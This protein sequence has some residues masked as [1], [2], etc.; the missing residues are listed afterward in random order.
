MNTWPENLLEFMN[1]NTK[2]ELKDRLHG[3]VCATVGMP[4]Q[5][6][7]ALMMRFTCGYDDVVIAARL[8]ISVKTVKASLQRAKDYLNQSTVRPLIE[9]GYLNG[10]N[11][12]HSIFSVWEKEYGV[13]PVDVAF[14]E[15]QIRSALLKSGITTVEELPADTISIRGIGSSYAE[16]IKQRIKDLNGISCFNIKARAEQTNEKISEVESEVINCEKQI[17]YTK[18]YYIPGTGRSVSLCYVGANS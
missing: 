12:I 4:D 7:K 1:I 2:I 5:D 11:I 18:R 8:G 14:P 3:I 10:M 16:V 9:L 15:A 13:I 6:Y 17:R